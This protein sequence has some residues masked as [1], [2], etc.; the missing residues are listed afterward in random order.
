MPTAVRKIGKLRMISR[1]PISLDTPVGEE[2]E[3]ALSDLVED[4][5]SASP[6]DAAMELEVRDRLAEV[7]NRLNPKEERVLR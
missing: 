3:S 4:R 6:A 2:G 5:A 7:L 1:S